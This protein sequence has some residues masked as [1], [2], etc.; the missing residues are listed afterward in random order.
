MCVYVCVWYLRV[1]QISFPPN[2]AVV[3]GHEV[4]GVATD[5]LHLAGMAV[6]KATSTHHTT[7]Q[8]TR[9]DQTLKCVSFLHADVL[10]EIPMFGVKNS[11]NVANAA[12]I[13]VFE[14]LRQWRAFDRLKQTDSE[15]RVE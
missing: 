3:F 5:V 9:P 7:P 15:P 1:R 14:V 12:S 6:Q 4:S 8:H 13:V 11:I 10:C 2:T